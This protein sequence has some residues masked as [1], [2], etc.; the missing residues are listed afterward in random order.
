MNENNL[1]QVLTSGFFGDGCFYRRIESSS[2]YIF[3]TNCI[4]KEYVIYKK[5]LLDGISQS[6][7]EYMNNGYKKGVIYS[8]ITRQHPL[9]DLIKNSSIEDNLNRLEYLG[10]ALWFYDDGS[11]HKTKHF[12]NLN[13]HAFSKEINEELFIP[14]FKKHGI[15]FRL[16]QDRKKDGRIFYYLSCNKLEGVSKIKWILENNRISCFDYK[17]PKQDIPNVF[18]DSLLFNGEVVKISDIEPDLK[19][20]RYLI[21]SVTCGH[22]YKGN[23]YSYL[24]SSSTT[25]LNGV[26]TSS[27]E[28]QAIP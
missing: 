24:V 14:F 13:T 19:Q 1:I 6:V 9:I 25:I 27:T 7:L 11:L 26:G 18:T 5:N 20:R 28:K 21:H 15:N 17:I 3:S 22:K 8:L 12:F 16:R 10:I 2:K 23:K 4:H